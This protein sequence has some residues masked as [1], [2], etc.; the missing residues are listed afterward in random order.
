MDKHEIDAVMDWAKSTDLVELSYKEGGKSF[1]YS[2]TPSPARA[3]CSFP[4]RHL[5]AVPCPGV[6]VFQWNEPGAPKRAAQGQPVAKGDLLGLVEGAG[7]PARVEAPCAGVVLSVCVEAGQ[8]VQYGQPL[9][10]LNATP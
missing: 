8:T 4:G 10:F 2:K 1:S 3:V 7:K 5:T 9:F 6:G